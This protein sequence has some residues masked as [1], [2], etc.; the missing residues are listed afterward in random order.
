MRK[1]NI[2]DSWSHIWKKFLKNRNFKKN[3]RQFNCRSMAVFWQHCTRVNL[4]LKALNISKFNFEHWK[5]LKKQILINFFVVIFMY[6]KRK[7]LGY[8]PFRVLHVLKIRFLYV[9]WAFWSK[10]TLKNNFFDIF[11]ERV[12]YKVKTI[13]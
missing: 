12:S 11:G 1:R 4:I 3:L 9:F 2:L 13:W 5:Y 6:L 10:F 7:F 8:W